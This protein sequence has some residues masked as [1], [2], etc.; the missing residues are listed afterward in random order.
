LPEWYI[1][2]KL[3]KIDHN[4]YDGPVDINLTLNAT[5]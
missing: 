3:E 1:V 5:K 4:G 2:E